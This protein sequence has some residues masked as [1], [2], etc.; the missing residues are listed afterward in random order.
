MKVSDLL[1]SV[2]GVLIIAVGAVVAALAGNFSGH[3]LV[4][5]PVFFVIV[6]GGF[7]LYYRSM[8]R[9]PK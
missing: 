4:F 9:R 1:R 6:T 8:N 3:K 7:W 5:L 2:G